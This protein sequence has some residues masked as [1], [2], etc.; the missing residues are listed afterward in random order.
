MNIKFLNVT[1]FTLKSTLSL[2]MIDNSILNNL[3]IKFELSLSGKI[4]TEVV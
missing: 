3:S 1:F 2:E 4:G